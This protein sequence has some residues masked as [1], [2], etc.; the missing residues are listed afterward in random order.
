MKINVGSSDRIIRILA[1]ASI[2]AAGF[3]F[4]TWWG[5]VGLLPLVTGLTKTCPAYMPFGLST[6]KLESEKQK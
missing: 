6:C 4:Q 5:V 3:V 2:I 1:G